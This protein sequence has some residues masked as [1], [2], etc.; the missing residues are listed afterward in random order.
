MAKH[1]DDFDVGT[2]GDVSASPD[3]LA[4]LRNSIQDMIGMEEAISTM[5]D[6]LK[7]AKASLQIMRT[8]RLPDLMA[9]IQ[10]DHFTHEGWEVKLSDFVS[11]SL[12][13][14]PEKRKLAMDWLEANEAEG[15]IKTDVKLTFG[16]SQHNEA[17]SV[18]EGL[19]EE[20]HAVDVQSGVH[21]QTLQSFAREKIRNG[22]DIDCELLGLY[23]GKVVKAKKVKS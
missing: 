20:G 1:V 22:E 16:R 23:T 5:E 8:G 14:D 4:Q 15:L 2:V 9:E 12:P 18:A 13:K 19:I 10:S 3:A 7:A 21:A 17:V 11:G 6:D